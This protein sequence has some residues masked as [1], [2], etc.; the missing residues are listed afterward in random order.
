MI[1]FLFKKKRGG[2]GGGGGEGGGVIKKPSILQLPN[3]CL[4]VRLS[5]PNLNINIPIFFFLNQICTNF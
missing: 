2:G 1:F 3:D 4:K 5:C